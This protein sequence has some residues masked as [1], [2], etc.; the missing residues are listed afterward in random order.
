MT[1]RSRQYYGPTAPALSHVQPP[2][3][4]EQPTQAQSTDYPL[5]PT[6]TGYGSI[7]Y[8]SAGY[9]STGYGHYP[10][11]RPRAQPSYTYQQ[12][13]QP[14]QTYPYVQLTQGMQPT[15]GLQPTSQPRYYPVQP[16]NAETLNQ[17]T[18]YSAQP[19]RSYAQPANEETLNQPT[20]PD[21]TV[22]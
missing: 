8:E 15:Q 4:Y 1:H 13:N 22:K 9:E 21:N 2:N 20:S 6:S 5:Q 18:Y 19:T 7:G 14:W 12:S 16:A 10:L 3:I 17:P 11:Q